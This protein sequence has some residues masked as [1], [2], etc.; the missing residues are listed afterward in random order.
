MVISLISMNLKFIRK[1]V[2]EAQKDLL[3]IFLGDLAAHSGRM[4]KGGRALLAACRLMARRDGHPCACAMK[5]ASVAN[6][7]LE[8]VFNWSVL[9]STREEGASNLTPE[10]FVELRQNFGTSARRED[11]LL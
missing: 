6:L 9:N 3:S 11:V 5:A 1:D 2:E 7:Q 4:S 10:R 8:Q